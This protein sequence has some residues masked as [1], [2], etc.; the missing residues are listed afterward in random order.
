MAFI[1]EEEVKKNIGVSLAPMIDFLFLMLV[2]FASLAVSRVTTKDTQIQ[3]VKIKEEVGTSLTKANTDIK[4]INV[5]ILEDGKYKWVTELRDYLM[6]SP[7]EIV[8]ELSTQYEK[9]ML[10]EAKQKTHILLKVDKRAP[11][12][13]IAKLI[14]VIRESGFSEVRPL[15]EVDTSKSSVASKTREE[16][17]ESY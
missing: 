9:G 2:F 6:T 8:E 1:P 11:W 7:E 5:S 13:S 17:Y 16:N 14:H 15:Y 12:E 4:L 10:P 3:L